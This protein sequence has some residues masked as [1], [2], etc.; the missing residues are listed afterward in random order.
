MSRLD[1]IERR[2][3]ALE[4]GGSNDSMEPRLKALEECL[5]IS[6]GPAPH[7]SDLVMCVRCNM[8]QAVN[9]NFRCGQTKCPLK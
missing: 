8:L 3:A 7:P 1:D 6:G 5:G 9:E 4:H 2:L